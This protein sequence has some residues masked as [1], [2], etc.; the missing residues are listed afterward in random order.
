MKTKLITMIAVLT[1]FCSLIGAAIIYDNG[2][3]IITT[4]ILTLINSL[5]VIGVIT[6]LK[7]K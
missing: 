1:I 2:L 4:L 3:T 7:V 6:L 5:L